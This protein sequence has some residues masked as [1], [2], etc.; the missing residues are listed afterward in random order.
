M[1]LCTHSGSEHIVLLTQFLNH[2]TNIP[3]NKLPDDKLHY[4]VLVDIEKQV[5]Q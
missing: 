1:H 2:C 3:I 4:Q 5:H